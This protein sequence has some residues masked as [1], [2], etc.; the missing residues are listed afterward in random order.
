[1]CEKDL[2]CTVGAGDCREGFICNDNTNS[3][4]Y[5]TCISE[6]KYEEQKA[7]GIT[8][9]A[10]FVEPAEDEYFIPKS[11]G[12]KG[13]CA[14]Y[15]PSEDANLVAAATAA[16]VSTNDIQIGY[17]C[18]SVTY[19]TWEED[20]DGSKNWAEF[21]EFHVLSYWKTNNDVPYDC[22]DKK[23]C[24][25]DDK[26][27]FDCIYTPDET[28]IE[29]EGESDNEV[30]NWYTHCPLL[31]G[32]QT[33]MARCHGD[34][35]KEGGGDGDD[36]WVRKSGA[37]YRFC[38]LCPNDYPIP[39]IHTSLQAFLETYDDSYEAKV[40]DSTMINYLTGDG[41]SAFACAKDKDS[42]GDSYNLFKDS[43][44]ISDR[45]ISSSGKPDDIWR[46]GEEYIDGEKFDWWYINKKTAGTLHTR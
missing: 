18:G 10:F 35:A 17:S 33:Y 16:G 39:C 31:K 21:D 6:S 34:G 14:E 12:T 7:E 38:M 37:N 5:E 43:S 2:S 30:V 24:K 4:T 44:Q 42:C 46:L 41:K 19:S 23:I 1:M 25:D 15:D 28:G 27:G 20:W 3:V 26:N 45:D 32:Y 13:W 29:G 11:D 9:E 8:T 40:K 36:K 22:D